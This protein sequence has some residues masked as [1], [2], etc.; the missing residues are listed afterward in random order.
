MAIA[1]NLVVGVADGALVASVLFVRRVVHFV[2][3]ARTVAGDSVT[4]VVNGE[5]FVA[6]ATIWRR[7]SYTP[8]PRTP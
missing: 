1:H 6:P 4:E 8:P 7:C 5:L 2:S 3:A